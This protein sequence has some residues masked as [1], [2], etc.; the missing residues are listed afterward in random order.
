MRTGI[1][2]RASAL[3]SAALL[4]GIGPV[5]AA[6]ARAQ[7]CSEEEAVV[8][9]LLDALG[10]ALS[11][12]GDY[13]DTNPSEKDCENICKKLQNGCKKAGS[14]YAKE[15]NNLIQTGGSAAGILCKTAVDPRACRAGVSEVKRESRTLM[16]DIKEQF[17]QLC[18]D[19]ALAA[20]CSNACNF[21]QYP[22]CCE[23]AFGGSCS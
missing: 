2:G 23:E 6:P 8:W 1:H 15:A 21:N 22:Q 3:L 20:S 9:E 7:S 16:R 10:Y 13:Y 12:V 14:G 18:A 4:L 17:K 5:A 11:M 19:P